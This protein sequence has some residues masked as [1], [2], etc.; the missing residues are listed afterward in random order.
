MLQ[1]I[2]NE[3]VKS[4]IVLPKQTRIESNKIKN[5][6]SNTFITTKT[7]CEMGGFDPYNIS[8]TPPGGYFMHNLHAR[9]NKC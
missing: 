6:D 3:Q 5:V 2:L 7:V 9:L 8:G 4:P 1:R